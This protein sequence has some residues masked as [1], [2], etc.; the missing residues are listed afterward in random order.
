MRAA[1]II[2]GWEPTNG[3]RQDAAGSLKRDENYEQ[4]RRK[5]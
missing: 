3:V 5:I 2:S 1:G 4:I